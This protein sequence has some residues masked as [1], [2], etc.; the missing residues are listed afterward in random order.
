MSIKTRLTK[1]EAKAQPQSPKS[2]AITVIEVFG[3]YGQ[4]SELKERW[5]W[6][7]DKQKF[8]MERQP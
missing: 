5:T 4:G 3:D 7:N 1:L 2:P 6:D 8:N